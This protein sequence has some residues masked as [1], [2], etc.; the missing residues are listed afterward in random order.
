MDYLVYEQPP[1][2]LTRLAAL[3]QCMGGGVVCDSGS[4]AV[5]GVLFMSEIRKQSRYEGITVVNVGN[6]HTVA[7][8]VY[9]ERIWGVYE[10]HTGFLDGDT[11]ADD[12]ERFRASALNFEDVF[13]AKGHGCM[14]LECP[15]KLQGFRPHT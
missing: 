15:E 6:S 13:E 12:L 1:V 5:L 11:L 7:F 9:D 2:E 10:H 4:A 14:N 3:R 8:L